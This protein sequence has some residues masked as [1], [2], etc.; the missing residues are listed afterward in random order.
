MHQTDVWLL[1]LRC[2]QIA[3]AIWSVSASD[4]IGD[5]IRCHRCHGLN[6]LGLFSMHQTDIWL[7]HH[8]C[9]RIRIVLQWE[10]MQNVQDDQIRYEPR[11]HFVN[12]QSIC[13]VS[14][15]FIAN[16]AA[17][18]SQCGE[19][20]CRGHEWRSVWKSTIQLILSS[21]FIDRMYGTSSQL[22]TI[23]AMVKSDHCQNR[24]RSKYGTSRF[25]LIWMVSIDD[26]IQSRANIVRW[27]HDV[28]WIEMIQNAIN[29]LDR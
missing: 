10:T 12:F 11:P 17:V 4:A 20:L 7:L 23:P 21:L 24:G 13:E 25:Y 29:Q 27:S 5:G 3:V 9:H 15:F 28:E 26:S 19:C 1:H 6:L 16:V 8:Q 18:E 14:R 22:S 2:G